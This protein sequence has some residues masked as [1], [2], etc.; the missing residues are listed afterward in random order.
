[1]NGEPVNFTFAEKT[2]S[3]DLAPIQRV[4]WSITGWRAATY[5][6]AARAGKTA[7]YAGR[8]GFYPISR[9]AGIIIKTEDD[10]AMA[11]ALA[12]AD[13]D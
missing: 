4:T 10:L 5:L 3:Q 9:A 7:T 13:L 8:V 12:P 6:A 2:N 11:E 1:M